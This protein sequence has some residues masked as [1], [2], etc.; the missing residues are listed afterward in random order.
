MRAVTAA[1]LFNAVVIIVLYYY[2]GIRSVVGECGQLSG[3]KKQL[4]VF[5]FVAIAGVDAL[6]LTVGTPQTV[7]GEETT[8]NPTY[9]CPAW[10]KDVEVA[11]EEEDANTDID[12]YH[13]DTK[14]VAQ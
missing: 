2:R 11:T 6:E 9:P 13:Y 5:S 8:G 10:E 12:N 1:M 3:I 4:S 14:N 7:G